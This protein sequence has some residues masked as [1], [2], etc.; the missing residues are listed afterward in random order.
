MRKNGG[1]EFLKIINITSGIQQF[2]IKYCD[3]REYA[4]VFLSKF[5]LFVL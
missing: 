1:E 2:P 5:F 4:P 3:R